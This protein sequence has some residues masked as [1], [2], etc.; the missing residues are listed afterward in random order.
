MGFGKLDQ[1]YHTKDKYIQE[2]ESKWN[3][4]LSV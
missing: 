1:R 4:T 3:C 2:Q